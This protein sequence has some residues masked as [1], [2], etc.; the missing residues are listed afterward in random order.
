MKK[1][2]KVKKNYWAT[3]NYP[4]NKA[5]GDLLNLGDKQAIAKMTELS[6]IYVKLVFNGKRHNEKIVS[7]ARDIISCRKQ[8][9]E[10]INDKHK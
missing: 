7:A 1:E 5:L 9:S 8:A 6:Y 4:E 2:G 10:M 3:Y